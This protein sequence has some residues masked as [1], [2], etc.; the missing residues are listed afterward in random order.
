MRLR[1]GSGVWELFVPGLEEG[2]YKF[3]L[4]HKDSETV[5]LKADPYARL[6]ER[7]PDTASLVAPPGEHQWC[8]QDWLEQ[9][10]NCDWRK[11]QSRPMSVYEVHLGS[12][13]RPPGGGFDNYRAI[14]RAVVRPRV[15]V[16]LHTHRA[17]T[18]HRAS[19]G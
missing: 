4:R 12:W 15:R 16:G 14:C 7:R 3:E 11:G 19:T 8:D 13:K 9:R 10:R 1:I 17:V 2:P 18:H 6:S 5:V